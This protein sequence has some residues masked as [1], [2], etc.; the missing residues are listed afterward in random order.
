MELST[1]QIIAAVVILAFMAITAGLAYWAGHTNGSSAEYQ[2]GRIHKGMEL[3]AERLRIEE[4]LAETQRLLDCRNREIKALHANTRIE[5]DDNAAVIRELRD[6]LAR[7]EPLTEEDRATLHAIAGKLTL[8]ADT[9]AGMRAHDHARL[10]RTFAL[11][12][13]DL[14]LRPAPT[15]Q[16]H[17]DTELIEWLEAFAE[18]DIDRDMAFVRFEAWPSDLAST[19]TL[20]AMIEQAKAYQE[21]VDTNYNETLTTANRMCAEKSWLVHGPQACGKS[22][23][24]QAIAK[25]LGLIDIRDDWQPGMPVAITGGLYL[26]NSEGPFEPFTR[27]I[28]PYETAM[29]IVEGNLTVHQALEAVA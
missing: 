21:E 20:R 5:A 16:R 1:T 25:A 24:A 8:A 15:K 4:E 7:V 29:Q 12:V 9:F 28:L 13:T 2:H 3:Q 26:T 10:A 14:A 19:E 23:N 22:S 18:F 27:R 6:Q 17:P 11:Y